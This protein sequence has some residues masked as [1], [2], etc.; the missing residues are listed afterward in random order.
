[1][2]AIMIKGAVAEDW[3]RGSHDSAGSGMGDDLGYSSQDW[4]ILITGNYEWGSQNES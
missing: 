1:M 2:E 4:G 3:E